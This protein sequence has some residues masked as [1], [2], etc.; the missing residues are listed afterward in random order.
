MTKAKV[1]LDRE[2]LKGFL[3]NRPN[4]DTD[5]LEAFFYRAVSLID[6]MEEGHIPREVV[7]LECILS[8]F[9]FLD[10]GKTHDEIKHAY[11][12]EA[13]REDTVTVPAAW[14][15]VIAEGW[16]KYRQAPSGKTFGEVM[17]LEGG[18]Q[19]A[20]RLKAAVERLNRETRLSNLVLV[21]WLVGN[22]GGKMSQ[23]KAI[24]RVAYEEDLS[25][26]TVRN[27]WRQRRD[28]KIER[29]VALGVLKETG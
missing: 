22:D 18:G 12:I 26:E 2:G 23:A 9:S 25:V 28:Q 13:W 15:R 4:G 29:L 19:G 8:A 21:E 7:A 16:L 6:E 1:R 3:G 20:P 11:P 17:N 5:F 10:D 27:A 24:E 14:L